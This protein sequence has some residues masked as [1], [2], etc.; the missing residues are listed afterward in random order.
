MDDYSPTVTRHQET[1]SLRYLVN[2]IS[3][4]VLPMAKGI[5]SEDPS[6]TIR[7]SSQYQV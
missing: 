4:E 2:D 5:S 7:P 1:H 6:R 3:Y